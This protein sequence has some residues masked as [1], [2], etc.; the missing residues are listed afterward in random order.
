MGIELLISFLLASITLSL[1]FDFFVLK[2]L[3]PKAKKKHHKL[4]YKI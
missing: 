2:K 1:M 4:F 3:F